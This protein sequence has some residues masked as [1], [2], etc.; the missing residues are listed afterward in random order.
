M[1]RPS[2]PFAAFLL[3]ALTLVVGA[4]E[5]S[6][7]VNQEEVNHREMYK[8]GSVLGGEGGI[9]L[10]GPSR[11]DDAQQA[12]SGLGVNSFLWRAS[13]DT[14]AFL[15]IAS[16]DPF[17]GV[18]LTDWY[19][20]ADGPGDR[21]KVNVYILDRQLRADALKVSVFRQ[22]KDNSGTWRDAT[23]AKETVSSM[24]DTILTRA[25][26]LRLAQSKP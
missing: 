12:G 8:Y 26:Q 10:L 14:L 17:G 1:I 20:P 3:L 11:R 18:I 21:F 5:G 16:A 6:H 22:V 23:V 9:S 2:S 19:S 4:C 13:L 15:P 24:E 25:R 7:A